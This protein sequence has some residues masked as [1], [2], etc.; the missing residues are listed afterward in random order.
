MF[1]VSEAFHN[2][3]L[4]LVC[5]DGYLFFKCVHQ[6]HLTM[7]QFYPL[8]MTP[9]GLLFSLSGPRT[10]AVGAAA[11]SWMTPRE[12]FSCINHKDTYTKSMLAFC[13]FLQI[14]ANHARMTFI[15]SIYRTNFRFFSVS[16]EPFSLA[17][18]AA[19]T[20]GSSAANASR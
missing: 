8:K 7:A 19:G 12:V 4:Q 1:V 13:R 2:V 10:A 20:F 18:S 5:K 15:Y 9:V 11:A 16:R 6:S 3:V 17:L 14:S